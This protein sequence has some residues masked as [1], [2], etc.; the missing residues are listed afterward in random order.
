VSRRDAATTGRVVTVR[1]VDDASLA[2]ALVRDAG[3]LAARMLDEGLTVEH[4]TS[5]SDVVSAADRAAE[6][7][8]AERLRE[9]R[10]GDA[11]VGEEGTAEDGSAS[12]AA[13]RTW[14]LDP[15]D[16]TYNFLSGLP[17]WCAAVGLATDAGPLLGAVFQPAAG[18]LW[19][20]GGGHPTTRN[21][22]PVE[23]LADRP[24]DEVSLATYL[25]PTALHDASLREPAL[26]V[27]AASATI[28]MLGSGSIELAAVAGGRVGA[29]IQADSLPW[30]WLPGAALVIGAGGV[31]QV[32][33]AAGH[34]WHVAGNRR[35]VADVRALLTR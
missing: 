35:A 2:A 32:V 27:S 23:P 4:K 19:V 14:Y 26:R 28:R 16:G 11:I 30:D 5:I 29:S 9:H 33:E 10:P 21:G 3:A 12:S 8:I 6:R 20:G 25:H 7:L 24:L 31:A 22:R 17:E 18:E 34:R 1:G 15:V 13:A